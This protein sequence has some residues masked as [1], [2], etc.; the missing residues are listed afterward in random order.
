MPLILAMVLSLSLSQLPSFPT[1]NRIPPVGLT[2]SVTMPSI[3]CLVVGY[4]VWAKEEMEPRVRLKARCPIQIQR[5]GAYLRLSSSKWIVEILIPET[6][7]PKP[8]LY[9]WGQRA[10]TIGNDTVNVQYGPV[11]GT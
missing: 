3:R 10:A 9:I 1:A 2:A 6:P 11:D 8:F 5:A 4:V 7:S